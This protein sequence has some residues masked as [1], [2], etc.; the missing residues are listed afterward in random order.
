LKSSSFTFLT[1]IVQ[2]TENQF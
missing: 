1:L 2:I